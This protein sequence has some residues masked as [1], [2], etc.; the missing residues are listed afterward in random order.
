MPKEESFEQL[1][2]GIN[3]LMMEP[4]MES[5]KESRMREAGG[6]EREERQANRGL[7][8]K[9]ER[10]RG[11]GGKEGNREEGKGG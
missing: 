5:E 3:V 10:G 4:G 8:L 7:G 2:E 11:R 9:K 1:E 6:R